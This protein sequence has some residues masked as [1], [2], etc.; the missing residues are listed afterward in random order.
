[1]SFVIV[2]GGRRCD[3]AKRNNAYAG[4]MRIYHILHL[5]V[6]P[7]IFSSGRRCTEKFTR[8]DNVS[9][10]PVCVG[11]FLVPNSLHAHYMHCIARTAPHSI[12]CRRDV[13]Y[14]LHFVV[15][16]PDTL[17]KT[18]GVSCSCVS[19]AG[20][21]VGLGKTQRK[22]P[23]CAR[24]C[25]LQMHSI[26]ISF[27]AL[28]TLSVV[29]LEILVS[30]LTSFNKLQSQRQHVRFAVQ[31]LE[32]FTQHR[33]EKSETTT[34]INAATSSY[35]III[36]AVIMITRSPVASVV[37]ILIAVT[38][39]AI[40]V[41]VGNP[42]E[43]PSQRW[44]RNELGLEV[45]PA[46]DAA[47]KESLVPE[48]VW[49][50]FRH[51]NGSRNI[52][53]ST[54]SNST[55]SDNL[56]RNRHQRQRESIFAYT[57]VGNEITGGAESFKMDVPQH[58]QRFHF[59]FNVTNIPFSQSAID[60]ALLLSYVLPAR[61][62]DATDN[63]TAT[64]PLLNCTITVHDIIEPLVFYHLVDVAQVLLSSARDPVIRMHV[65]DAV[66][67][68]LKDPTHVYGLIVQTFCGAEQDDKKE[69]ETGNRRGRR[70]VRES[71]TATP[72]TNIR[73]RRHDGETD[74][75]WAKHVPTLLVDTRKEILKSEIEERKEEKLSLIDRK[76][77]QENMKGMYRRKKR[78]AT[79]EKKLETTTEKPLKLALE[80]ATESTSTMVPESTTETAATTA[81]ESTTETAS[82]PESASTTA[83]ETTTKS[84]AKSGRRR[85][86]RPCRQ[87]SMYVDFHSI[88]WGDWIIGPSG[89]QAQICTGTCRTPYNLNPNVHAMLQYEINRLDQARAPLPCCIATEV[90][91]ITVMYKSSTHQHLMTSIKGMVASK[92]GCR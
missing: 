56:R 6:F 52:S 17:K 2:L 11:G 74:E 20:C 12:M 27:T 51:F 58:H 83:P 46:H 78:S 25:I 55:S 18:H 72:T 3:A 44:L 35:N 88:G 60:A 10:H 71:P 36:F 37:L 70:A 86:M 75:Q 7:C 69:D 15:L 31:R 9:P 85:S 82:T 22:L 14:L 54:S 87:E 34:Q 29:Y 81:P 38:C 68:W 80:T 39:V 77:L 4:Q 48:M 91:S 43:P 33:A 66:H 65:G 24:A 1:M 53:N 41:P 45:L 26:S 49:R 92:C 57:H 13:V 67:R 90:E 19:A 8:P 40:A 61:E 30:S 16:L 50:E 21:Y 47:T 73:L 42:D 84:K 23:S 79:K 59:V 63:T 89:Y 28:P 5:S 62:V 76:M 32:L 64:P